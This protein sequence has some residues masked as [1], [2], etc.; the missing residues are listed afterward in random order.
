MLLTFEV[1]QIWLLLLVV[2]FWFL[3]FEEVL[4]VLV[5]LFDGLVVGSAWVVGVS[6]VNVMVVEMMMRMF[7]RGFMVQ[8]FFLLGERGIIFEVGEC[9]CLFAGPLVRVALF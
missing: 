8:V 7:F 2:L 5:M 6:A 4:H 3:L 1:M 9:A